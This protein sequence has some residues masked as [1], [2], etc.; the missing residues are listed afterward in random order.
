MIE[1]FEGDW[2][3]N[4]VEACLAADNP[5]KHDG[6]PQAPGK[7]AHTIAAA[8]AWTAAEAANRR[9]NIVCRLT[10]AKFIKST[11][12]VCFFGLR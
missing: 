1:L 11:H 4:M 5:N 7:A 8:A 3:D 12:T 9:T 6:M 2:L 10:Y